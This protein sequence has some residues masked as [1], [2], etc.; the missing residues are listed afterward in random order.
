MSGSVIHDLFAMISY[1]V[2]FPVSEA[3]S[4]AKTQS[5]HEST[6]AAA[7]LGT[8]RSAFLSP[9]VCPPRLGV[10]PRRPA[11]GAAHVFDRRRVVRE[12][13][14]RRRRGC[15]HSPRAARCS[16]REWRRVPIAAGR[17][18]AV[19]EGR[20]V[21]SGLWHPP[22]ENHHLSA[23]GAGLQPAR[24]AGHHVVAGRWVAHS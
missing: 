8:P 17:E 7:A 12:Y 15:S 22:R 4:A 23:A 2:L 3:V 9:E 13:R 24:W 5:H 18:V 19:A 16:R 11:E 6:W 20:W 21:G 14:E 1:P 10:F